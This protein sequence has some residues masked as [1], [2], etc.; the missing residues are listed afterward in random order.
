MENSGNSEINPLEGMLSA[1]RA[2]E[3]S[4]PASPSTHSVIH[5]RSFSLVPLLPP[6]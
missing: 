5:E 2:E 3:E 6:P 4:Q 1:E